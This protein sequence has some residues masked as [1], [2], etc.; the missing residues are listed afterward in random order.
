MLPNPYPTRTQNFY[1]TLPVPAGIPVPEESLAQLPRTRGLYIANWLITQRVIVVV[2]AAAAAAAV[3]P[4]ASS[5][6]ASSSSR[7][8]SSKSKRSRSSSEIA[9]Y[10]ARQ[11]IGLC[12]FISYLNLFYCHQLTISFRLSSNLMVI[13]TISTKTQLV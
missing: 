1:P 3:G 10:V 4:S 13:T 6:S 9:Y 2:A 5:I 7:I 12:G 8:S 11:N